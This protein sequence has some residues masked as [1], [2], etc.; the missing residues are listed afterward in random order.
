MTN[1][2]D[3]KWPQNHDEIEAFLT[4]FDKAGSDYDKDEIWARWYVRREQMRRKD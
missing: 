1:L 4:I 3:P 2:D